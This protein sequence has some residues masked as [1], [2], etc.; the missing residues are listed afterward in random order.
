MFKSAF[1]GFAVRWLLDTGSWV[2]GVVL[3][4]LQLYNTLPPGT[5][6]IVESALAGNWGSITLA[7]AFSVVTWA[8][9]QVFK[10]HATVKPQVVTEDGKKAD[11]NALPKET[12]TVVNRQATTVAAKKRSN[13]LDALASIFKR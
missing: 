8:V 1:A 12:Q 5:Q 7:G 4:L 10:L 3:V 11:L 9:T 13:P 2:S 6:G